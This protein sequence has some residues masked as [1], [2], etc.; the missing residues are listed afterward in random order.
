MIISFDRLVNLFVSPKKS[1]GNQALVASKFF[2]APNHKGLYVLIPPWRGR[3]DYYALTRRKLMKEGYSCIEYSFSPRMLSTNYILTRDLFKYVCTKVKRDI[4]NLKIEKQFKEINIIGTSIGC[5]EVLMIATHYRKFKK[6]ILVA[7]GNSLAESMWNG[8][9]TQQLRKDMEEK[10]ITL[11]LLKEQW[12]ELDPEN[13]LEG[14]ER[15]EIHIHLSR[16]DK[17][18]P[19]ELGIRLVDAMQRKGLKP[20]VKENTYLGHYLT[21]L[22]YYLNPTI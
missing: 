13:N 12:K 19:Y 17:I 21:I 1:S 18:I 9:R 6:V 10:H 3:L 15:K 11:K 8:I 5:V 14:L 4:E 7:P 16:S 22:N 2:E 20:L